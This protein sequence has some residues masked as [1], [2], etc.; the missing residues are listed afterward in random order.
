MYIVKEL[1]FR[2]ELGLGIGHRCAMYIFCQKVFAVNADS[3][4]Q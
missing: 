1:E 2:G 3:V 4:L